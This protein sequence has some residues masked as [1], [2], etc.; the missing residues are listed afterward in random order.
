MLRSRRILVLAGLLCLP[1]VLLGA[2]APPRKAPAAPVNP[3]RL[4][5]EERARLDKLSREDHADMLRQLGI[6]RLRPG[7][8]GFA[9]TGAPNAANYDP[10]KANPFPDWPEVL[11]LKTGGTVS[12][13]QEWWTKRRPEI[14]QDFERE[15]YGRVPP[16]VPK[17]TWT[18]AETVETKVGGQ[19]V[20]ARR[21]VGHADNS[22]H[23]AIDVEIQMA[24]VLPVHAQGPVPVL[25]MFGWGGGMPDDPRP[26]FPGMPE[27]AAPPSTDQLIASGWGYVSLNTASIQA[28]NGAGLTA[29]IIGL[30]NKGQ[31]RTPE[32]W[33]ALRAWAWG[34]ARALDYL[35]TLPAVDA[36]RVGIEGVSRYGK[37]ALVTMAFEPRFAVVLV[38]SSGEGG[39]KPHRRHFGEAVENL[40]GS[41]AYH[42]MAGNFLK[43][44]AAE[45]SFGSRNAGDI[46]VDA[47]ELLALCAPRPTF[48]SYG[49]PEKGDAHWLDQQGSYMA[50]V[51][52]GPAFRLLGARDLGVT[53]GYRVAKLPPV[54][55]GLLDGELAW[56]Q[57][58]GGH[59][60]RTNMSFFIAWANRLLRHTPPPVPAHEPRMRADQNSHLAHQ[61]LL[62]KAKSGG[63]DVYFLGDSI[64]RRWGATDYPDLLAHWKKTFHGWNAA[65]FGWGADRTENILWRL[66]NGELDGVD[67]K[68]IVLLAGTNNVGRE[69]GDDAKIADVTRGLRTIVE[70]CRKK[71]S[72]ATIV[73][74]AIFPR[75]DNPA[76]MP[77]IARI[78]A[79][80]AKIADGKAVRFLDVNARLADPT[81]KLFEGHDGRRAASDARGVRG[82]GRGPHAHPQGVAR[83]TCQHGP[84]PGPDRGPERRRKARRPVVLIFDSIRAGTDRPLAPAVYDFVFFL[85]TPAGWQSTQATRWTSCRLSPD[86][87]VVSIFSTSRPQF[88]SRG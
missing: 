61:Q 28:D 19:P 64:V 78:N 41:G 79:E 56:R 17:V 42:W 60:D 80:L 58:D 67:P 15:V 14:V 81:G 84:R 83:A 3:F 4:S 43:Y 25:V 38:G 57:H 7:Y 50:T 55:K 85:G 29:G 35:E 88:D 6:E 68:V 62:A 52:A 21:V 34:A 44:G 70:T 24:V 49:I 40:T 46:P 26:R 63:I 31:R 13:A 86:L 18:V 39:A 16:D 65:N 32:Q 2:Q 45:A 75:S 76:A 87:N 82:L 51:A 8:D 74:T 30:A 11:R 22:A 48:V 47:H 9:A 53:E 20:V 72:A 27:P 59:E 73:L 33:G 37:A 10:A 5:P 77:T 69:P 1:T 66:E 12:T 71:A 54:N 36:K 23:P